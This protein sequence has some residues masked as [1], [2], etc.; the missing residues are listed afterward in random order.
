MLNV[1][2]Q[3]LK[4]RNYNTENKGKGEQNGLKDRLSMDN[5]NL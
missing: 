3:G 5:W 4:E 1:S 2:R